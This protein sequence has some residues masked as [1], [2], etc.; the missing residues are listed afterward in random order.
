MLSRFR[1]HN[2]RVK[3]SKCSFGADKVVYLGHT[4]SH[5]GIH[6]DPA[7]TEVMEDLPS[8]SNLESL[9]LFLGLVGYH[10]KFIP[11]FATVSAPLTAL[12]KK[13]LNSYGL[14]NTKMLF[15]Y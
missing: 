7:K 9:R 2:L 6:I 11:D 14:T 10:R 4:V 8:P 3:A 12:T 5:E 13:G 15:S 1:Q